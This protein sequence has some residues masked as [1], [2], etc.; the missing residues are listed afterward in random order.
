[1]LCIRLA[2][3]GGLSTLPCGALICICAR[4]LPRGDKVKDTAAGVCLLHDGGTLG[5]SSTK[6]CGSLAHA[7]RLSAQR[8]CTRCQMILLNI[9]SKLCIMCLRSRA[10]AE[11]YPDTPQTDQKIWSKCLRL[12]VKRVL[13]ASLQL[14]LKIAREIGVIVCFAAV[15]YHSCLQRVRLR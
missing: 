15:F 6:L 12:N 5:G 8:Q 7:G 14:K 10:P 2:H 1:M 4:R 3:C 9:A 13:G 11:Q